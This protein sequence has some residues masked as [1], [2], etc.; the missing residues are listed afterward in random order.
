MYSII[1]TMPPERLRN[2]ENRLNSHIGMGVI[3]PL[4]YGGD[5]NVSRYYLDVTRNP[6]DGGRSLAIY[7]DDYDKPPGFYTWLRSVVEDCGGSARN[8]IPKQP[9][10]STIS[11]EE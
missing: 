10:E 1:G 9:V 6:L 5:G 3:V 8:E 11:L 2:L 7:V 4:T